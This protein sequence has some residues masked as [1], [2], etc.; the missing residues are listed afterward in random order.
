M[1][2]IIVTIFILFTLLFLNTI[3]YRKRK[4]AFIET[5]PF[6]ISEEI[7]Q[8]L[9][10]AV[11]IKTITHS[12]YSENDL[13]H[14]RKFKLFI[15]KSYPLV[16]QNLESQSLNDYSYFIKWPGADP[17]Q[18]P[19]LFIAHFDVVPVVE[20]NWS[21]DPFGAE[22]KKG[23]LWGRGTLD[24]KNTLTAILESAEQLLKEGYVPERTVYMAFGGDEETQGTEGAGKISSYFKEQ[25]IEFDWLLDEGGVVAENSFS[26][27]KCPMALIGISE[28]GYVNLRISCKGQSG[29]S[30]MPPRHTAAGHIARAVSIIENHPFKTVITPTIK[31]FLFAITPYVSFPIAMVMANQRVFSPLIRFLLRR[32]PQSAALIGTTQAVTILSSGNKENVLPSEGEAIVNFRILPGE[33]VASVLKRIEYLLRNE[34]VRVEIFQKNDA[35]D[36]IEESS[37]EEDGYKL[38]DSVIQGVFPQS[39]TIPYMMTGATDSKHYREVC[40]NIYRFAPMSLKS[41]EISLI[42]SADERIS[43]ENY[44]KAIEFYKTLFSNI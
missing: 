10:E 17:D 22:V 5:I 19:V 16:Y 21:T 15:E 2:I 33:T 43:I 36:P 34:E 12:L 18:N 8:K 31:S 28:K 6:E 37:I 32:S 35:N 7:V 41:E 4:S 1:Y 14:F 25:G 29:H 38:I 27:V 40:R 24:T 9:K 11:S 20:E 30:S 23:Y 13:D 44:R 39:A 3:R 26:M 42:H